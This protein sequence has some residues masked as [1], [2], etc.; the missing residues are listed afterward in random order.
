MTRVIL[1]R[2][3]DSAVSTSEA[4]AIIAAHHGSVVNAGEQTMLVDMALKTSVDTIRGKLPGWIVSEQRT[5][6]IPIPDTRFKL[7]SSK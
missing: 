7:R 6:K 1:R 3:Q 5:A 2:S 4:A